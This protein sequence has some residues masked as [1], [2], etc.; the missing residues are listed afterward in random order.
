M[1][2]PAPIHL[3]PQK[4]V[5]GI[6]PILDRVPYLAFFEPLDGVPE[7]EVDPENVKEYPFMFPG[8]PS[9][10]WLVFPP[11]K[12]LG[13]VLLKNSVFGSVLIL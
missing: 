13:K 1:G 2:T 9:V 7:T 3:A 11:R 6:F 5:P 10:S 12:V 4:G 8:A